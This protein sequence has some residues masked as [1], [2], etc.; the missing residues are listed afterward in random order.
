M[1]RSIG[2]WPLNFDPHR[3]FL[4]YPDQIAQLASHLHIQSFSVLGI[5]GGS[6]YAL[7]CAKMLPKSQLKHVSIA[8]GIAPMNLGLAG[9][10]LR[11]R[12]R[13]T[14]AS[15]FPP[16]TRLFMRI[17]VESPAYQERLRKYL[18]KTRRD[19]MPEW[20]KDRYPTEPKSIDQYFRGERE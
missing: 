15:W 16:F 19:D 10:P 9:I 1:P 13:R 7:A 5:S 6:S 8:A 14:L 17:R 2:H 18:L 11:Y 3:R 20:V 4:D 12:I